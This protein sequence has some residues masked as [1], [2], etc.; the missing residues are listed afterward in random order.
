MYHTH[1]EYLLELGMKEKLIDYLNEKQI[2]RLAEYGLDHH[3]DPNLLKT[4]ISLASLERKGKKGAIA[5][6]SE[7][8][9]TPLQAKNL[10]KDQIMEILELYNSDEN[11]TAF[12]LKNARTL[13]KHFIVSNQQEKVHQ[14]TGEQMFE[15][16]EEYVIHHHQKDLYY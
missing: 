6:V 2:A 8:I 13:A 3:D 7:G 15:L 12:N 10:D 5:I 4:L 11:H 1:K 14:E 9:I 16:H